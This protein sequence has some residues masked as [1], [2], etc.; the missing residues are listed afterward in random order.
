MIVFSNVMLVMKT[1]DVERIHM[2]D[3]GSKSKLGP[4]FLQSKRRMAIDTFKRA[5]ITLKNEFAPCL[6]RMGKDM[7]VRVEVVNGTGGAEAYLKVSPLHSSVRKNGAGPVLNEFKRL[8]NG[9]VVAE[10]PGEIRYKEIQY[11]EYA[12]DYL[13]FE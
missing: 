11:D 10:L 9:E 3:L 7:L 2:K 13:V 4:S 12:D 8:F 5:E 1:E 6:I